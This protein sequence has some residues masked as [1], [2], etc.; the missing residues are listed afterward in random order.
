[1]TGLWGI[2]SSA[3]ALTLR[4]GVGADNCPIRLER[5]DDVEEGRSMP[6]NAYGFVRLIPIFGT[7]VVTYV[8][9]SCA[10]PVPTPCRYR[11][12]SSSR[13]GLKLLGP[14]DDRLCAPGVP[15]VE[16]DVADVEVDVEAMVDDR[17]SGSGD[18]GSGVVF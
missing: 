17:K 6:S 13:K 16:E 15:G 10:G 1:M 5:G 18:C 4:G 7:G 8:K 2:D 3:G 12:A 11:R 9:A 14:P